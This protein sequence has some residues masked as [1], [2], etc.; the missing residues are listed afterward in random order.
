MAVAAQTFF[1]ERD[2]GKHFLILCDNISSVQV[3]TTGRGRNRVIL[4]SARALWMVQALL[5]IRLSYEHISGAL[6]IFADALSRMHLSNIYFDYAVS[7][8]KN[9]RLLY[10]H[11]RLD[12]F[13]NFS[14]SLLSRAGVPMVPGPSC[15]KATPVEGP[16]DRQES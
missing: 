11:P 16:W 13:K 10:V 1:S 9:H 8:I 7:V 12:I 2:R 6:N 14:P 4:E 15:S 5:D 3:F